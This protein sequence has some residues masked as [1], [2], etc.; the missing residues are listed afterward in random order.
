M[1]HA[2]RCGNVV[3]F[4]AAFV[5]AHSLF[6]PLVLGLARQPSSV[7]FFHALYI[8]ALLEISRVICRIYS[9][10]KVDFVG[11]LNRNALLRQSFSKAIGSLGC[12]MWTVFSRYNKDRLRLLALHRRQRY[13]L[14]FSGL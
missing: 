4:H 8:G 5:Q 11:S 13:K 14:A 6:A 3:N 10:A 12:F 1:P 7:F 9:E 2:Q